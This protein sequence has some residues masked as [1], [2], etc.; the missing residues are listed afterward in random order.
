MPHPH[1]A[2]LETN[3]LIYLKNLLETLGSG[4][5][6]RPG[7]RKALLIGS[8]YPGR[9]DEWCIHGCRD[10]R[11]MRDFLLGT[12]LHHRNNA[13]LTRRHRCPWL[14][15]RRYPDSK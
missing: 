6:R 15:E 12:T 8:N 14:S 13:E 11:D 9:G 10:I 3:F 1:D 5:R 2:N 7:I 4:R